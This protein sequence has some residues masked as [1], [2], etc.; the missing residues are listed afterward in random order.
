MNSWGKDPEQSHMPLTQL[1]AECTSVYVSLTKKYW[2]N[3]ITIAPSQSS[4]TSEYTVGD[5][6]YYLIFIELLKF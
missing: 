6:Y 1:F 3:H 5:L 4:L 2:Q